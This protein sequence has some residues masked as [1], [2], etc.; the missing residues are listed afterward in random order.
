[1]S[2]KISYN[3]CF[4][5]LPNGLQT[6]CYAPMGLNIR[7]K[8]TLGGSLPG[9][10]IAPVELGLGTPMQ[11]LWLRE[12]VDMRCNIMM[13]G[14]VKKTLKKAHIHLVDR[15]L[16]R[17]QITGASQTNL[18][19]NQQVHRASKDYNSSLRSENAPSGSIG[20]S[21][22][23]T[24][25]QLTSSHTTTSQASYNDS[26]LNNRASWHDMKRQ[27]DPPMETSHPYYQH[28]NRTFAAELHSED[29]LS[30]KDSGRN[31]GYPQ[32]A[33]LRYGPAELE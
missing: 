2:G 9:E 28:V 32:P 16:V 33:P 27:S 8:W 3:A 24:S 12:D 31:G 10:P 18:Q 5:D 6:H 26:I 22:Y 21:Q 20:F 13:T 25:P 11:G 15:L 23:T 17:T 29:R 4:H 19:V 1:M 30:A 14:F 7:G